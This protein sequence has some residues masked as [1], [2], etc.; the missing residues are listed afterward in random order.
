MK[1][2]LLIVTLLMVGCSKKLVCTYENTTS[3]YT[4]KQKI[5]IT[6]NDDI[7]TNMDT[8]LSFESDEEEV[9]KTFKENVETV[10]ND[11]EKEI[12]SKIEE[13]DNSI[14]LTFS[15][16]IGKEDKIISGTND[17]TNIKLYFEDNGYVCK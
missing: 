11:L 17:Y 13:K 5:T 9:I 7:P 1:K 4:E 3:K 10:K 6:F 15:K 2:L 12:E 16:K 8:V 14:S